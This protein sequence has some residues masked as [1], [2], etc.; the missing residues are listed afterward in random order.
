MSAHLG[1]CGF[2]GTSIALEETNEC[3]NCKTQQ[4]LRYEEDLKEKTGDTE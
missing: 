2:C 4:P 3:P 1:N